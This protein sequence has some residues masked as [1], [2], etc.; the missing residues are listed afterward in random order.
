[1]YKFDKTIDNFGNF[2]IIIIVPIYIVI[3][4]RK[5]RRDKSCRLT[6]IAMVEKNSKK[7]IKSDKDQKLSELVLSVKNNDTS[8]FVEL[9]GMFSGTISN[10]AHSFCLPSSEYEDL[11]QEARMALYRAAVSY[12]PESAKFSTYAL[13]C[14]TNAMISFVR[15]YSSQSGK[16][17]SCTS[18]DEASYGGVSND[19]P[20]D[21]LSANEFEKMLS[22]VGFAGL[23]DVERRVMGLKLSG[24][25][26]AGIADK[27]G[28]PAKSIE[29][30]L[31]RARRKLKNYI[32]GQ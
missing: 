13:T 10:L 29:N 25:K 7:T 16:E 18:L 11:C 23:L 4:V 21:I 17:S 26:V 8:S 19:T 30:T 24:F 15:K 2:G 32:D 9:L 12:N 3:W 28:K 5:V 1:M 20:Q 22:T 27:L 14:M 31:F 6:G